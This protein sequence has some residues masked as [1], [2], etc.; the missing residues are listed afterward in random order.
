MINLTSNICESR[1]S[2]I[3]ESAEGIHSRSDK[4]IGSVGIMNKNNLT[5]NIGESRESRILESAVGIHSR[6]YKEIGLVGILN[7]DQFNIQYM[8]K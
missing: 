8:R 5:S 1:E 2:R 3:L 7:Y 4:E 6:S